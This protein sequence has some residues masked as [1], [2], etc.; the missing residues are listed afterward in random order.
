MQVLHKITYTDQVA[1]TPWQLTLR[2]RVNKW[3]QH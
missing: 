3:N 1:W 2:I